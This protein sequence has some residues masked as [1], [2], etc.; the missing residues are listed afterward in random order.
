[1][2]REFHV[3]N[4]GAGV[5]STTLY[6]MGMRGELEHNFDVAIFAD[7]GDE[8][9]SVYKHLEW[10]ESLDGP[11]IIRASRGC[12]GDDLQYGRGETNRCAS[13]PAFTALTEGQPLAMVRR[14]CTSDYKIDVITKAVRQ[15]VVGLKPRQ[16]MPKDVHV[17]QY[18]GFSYDE[19]GRAAR[20]RGRFN[21]IPWASCHFPLIDEVMK[22]GDC[23]RWLE[24]HGGVPHETPRSACVFCPFHSNDEWRRVKA[25]PADWERACQIDDALR[26]ET[27]PVN[28]SGSRSKLVSKLYVH[29][30]C[31]PLR[32]VDLDDNQR[33][34]FDMEC[35][36]GCGL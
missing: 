31:R 32:D 8:P 33:S 7:P 21:S 2:V 12:L 1:M 4:L 28:Q 5:Q 14:Q 23:L 13:I 20:M 10:L 35:E 34:L 11:K 17:H 29:K 6:L 26:D 9:E 3:L 27:S 24:D 30:S 25:N 15:D 18:V 22:R 16:R 36:G 19:P